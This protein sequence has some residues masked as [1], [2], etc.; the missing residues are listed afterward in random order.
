M[1]FGIF[2]LSDSSPPIGSYASSW[3]DFTF[4]CW[5]ESRST[6]Q[7]CSCHLDGAGKF[8]H[9]IHCKSLRIQVD[10]QMSEENRKDCAWI[11]G[12]S[13]PN[14]MSSRKRNTFH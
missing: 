1:N 5:H 6:V 7:R 8:T 10:L 4:D 3:F 11:K 9:G 13:F 14:R 2:G 12:L